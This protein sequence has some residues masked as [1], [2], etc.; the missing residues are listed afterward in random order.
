MRRY[1]SYPSH[2]FQKNNINSSTWILDT[3]LSKYKSLSWGMN[4][5]S[6][7]DLCIPLTINRNYQVIPIFIAINIDRDCTFA[8]SNQ[9]NV[10]KWKTISRKP[11][12]IFTH[13]FKIYTYHYG[14]QHQ[15]THNINIKL[16]LRL[17]YTK[18]YFIEIYGVIDLYGNELNVV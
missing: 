10:W 9:R 5:G 17:G 2:I 3:K 7:K 4:V 14:L 12:S 1:F 16:W 13:C 11:C 6:Y 8:M 18:S 15:A